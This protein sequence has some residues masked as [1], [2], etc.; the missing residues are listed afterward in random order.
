MAQHYKSIGGLCFAYQQ[1]IPVLTL[2]TG[3]LFYLRHVGY[4]MGIYS[5]KTGYTSMYMCDETT[6]KKAQT[7]LSPVKHYVDNYIFEAVK[8]L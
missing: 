7:N 4:N 1:N 8:I 2:T 5:C 6:G 3:E